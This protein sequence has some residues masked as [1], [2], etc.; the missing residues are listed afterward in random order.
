MNPDMLLILHLRRQAAAHGWHLARVTRSNNGNAF[1]YEVTDDGDQ[2]WARIRPGTTNGPVHT[3]TPLRV[4]VNTPDGMLSV[5]HVGVAQ[6]VRILRAYFGWP[7]HEQRAQPPER[8]RALDQRRFEASVV[9]Q[10]R[11]FV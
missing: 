1:H 4:A 3:W 11:A 7:A 6:A 5:E 10:C 9:G 2:G 8:V